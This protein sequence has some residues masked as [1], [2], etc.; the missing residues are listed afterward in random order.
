MD[1]FKVKVSFNYSMFEERRLLLL[2]GL[3]G[4]DLGISS[5]WS[6]LA[7]KLYVS[8]R[9]DLVASMATYA[10][11]SMS[12]NTLGIPFTFFSIS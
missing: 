8:R 5:W 2:G 12:P 1:Y 4:D 9:M 7:V 10:K 3:S 6:S 11:K